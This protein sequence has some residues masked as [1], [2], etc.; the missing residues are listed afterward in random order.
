VRNIYGGNASSKGLIITCSTEPDISPALLFDPVR[1]RQILSNFI[2]NAIKFTS[3]G[4]IDIKAV[5]VDRTQGHE[6][7]RISV[8]DGGI[9]I[10]AE[11]QKHLF[12][13]FSQA[14]SGTAQR[15]GGTGLG[16]AICQR[17]ARLMGGVIEMTS[18][19]DMGTT[20]SL[21]VTLPI[22]DPNLL[23]RTDATVAGDSLDTVTRA[24]RAP[25]SAAQAE[26]EGTLLLLVDDH[27]T[28]RALLTRQAKTLGYASETA[29]D[30]VEALE[31]WKSGRFA[32]VITDCNMPQ[33]N[34]YEL[35]R[36][37]RRLEPGR[38]GRRIPLIAC[39]ANALRGEAETCFA[40]G[41]D[42]YLAKPVEL[43]QLA[44]KLDQWLPLPAAAAAPIDR[45]ALA[46]ICG[47]DANAEH[48][49]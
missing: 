41:M 21:T 4:S 33:M 7:V 36:S 19:P 18:A 31:K 6:R 46:A 35:A 45:S 29:E 1:L 44:I 27:P 3:Q 26:S 2:S 11:N 32:I 30:G 42:D 15:F 47:G 24:R 20:M 9:G 43:A 22:A 12:Q 40:A 13:P 38:G 17:I 8:K 49:S 25:P 28:N 14:D 23:P 37:I 16:L 10:S 48:D 39:T 5:L 34:G